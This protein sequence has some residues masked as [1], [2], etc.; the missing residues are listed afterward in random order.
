MISELVGRS[1]LFPTGLSDGVQENQ[2]PVR[3]AD[4]WSTASCIPNYGPKC[5]PF[6]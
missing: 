6:L 2:P 5:L 3:A 1:S 4:L